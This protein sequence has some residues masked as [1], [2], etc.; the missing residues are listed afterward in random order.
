MESLPAP[1][2]RILTNT[3][4]RWSVCGARK[5]GDTIVM[6]SA[7]I[8]SREQALVRLR[9]L[10]EGGKSQGSPEHRTALRDAKASARDVPLLRGSAELARRITSWAMSLRRQSTQ[11]RHLLGGGRES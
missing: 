2:V 9:K 6:W 4:I 7:R 8:P 1:P 10:A 3:S 5:V 11:V